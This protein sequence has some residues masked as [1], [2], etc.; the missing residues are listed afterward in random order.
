MIFGIAAV[1]IL[2][3]IFSGVAVPL[4]FLGGSF[5]VAYMG[6]GS[7][8]TFATNA[9]YILNSISMLA[10]PLFIVGGSLIE[11][12]GIANVLIRVADKM[13]HNVKGGLTATIPV[14]SCFFGALCGSA[15]AT[16]NTLSTAMVP[17]LEK[18]GY[19]KAYLAA[20]IAA[21]S[22]FGF[23][24]PPNVNAIIFASV[25]S[26]SVGALFMAT[27]VPGLIWAGL[28]L[29]IN[30][31]I[32]IKYYHPEYAGKTVASVSA[33]TEDNEPKE[34]SEK[35]ARETISRNRFF[36]EL[37]VAVLMPVI[38]LGGIYGGIFTATEAGAI[39]CLYGA[40]KG[41]KDVSA[42]VIM[43]PM[44]LI[45]SRLMTLNHI[46]E[47]V[48][49]LMLGITNNR[50]GL[51]LLIDLLLFFIGFF[52]DG[53]VI[54]LTLVPLLTPIATACGIDT[55]QLA[56]IVFVS[57][58]I[59]SIT[60]PMATCLMACSRVCDVPIHKLIKPILP[61]LLFGAL[62]ILLLVSFVPV[63]STWLPGLFYSF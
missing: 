11:R 54:I 46:P 2:L 28:Y 40:I 4:A 23:M 32:Y 16:A 47:L 29:I 31:I 53:N 45:F 30:R 48:A 14:V 9:F 44:T 42:L 17:E 5:F 13:L 26:A 33:C 19:D 58:G 61:F 57:I 20:L 27:I 36:L 55:I 8:G 24:I 56:V 12:S 59:G 43:F 62:P 22:P 49:E 3:M 6:L 60:P 41:V 50:I 1:L 7:T 10:I 51:I 37:V 15:L 39:T 52:L 25:S 38:V 63:V 34:E 18:K 35:N 21:S